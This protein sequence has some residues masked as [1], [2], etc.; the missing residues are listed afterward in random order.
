M[1]LY[2]DCDYFHERKYD[3]FAPYDGECETC[4]RFDICKAAYDKKTKNETQ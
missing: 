2:P 4:Y 1:K 3:E